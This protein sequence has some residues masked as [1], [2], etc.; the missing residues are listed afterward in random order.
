MTDK[1]TPP[2]D[3]QIVQEF[4]S[5][6]AE[7]ADAGVQYAQA[8]SDIRFTDGRVTFTLDPLKDGVQHWAL[9]DRLTPDLAAVFSAPI[10]DN[11]DDAAWLRQRVSSIAV[12][13]VDGRDLYSA[14]AE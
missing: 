9:I 11:T 4:R 8:V 3:E 5:F 7:R 1:T 13:D 12:V 10:K 14:A 2:T 6:I